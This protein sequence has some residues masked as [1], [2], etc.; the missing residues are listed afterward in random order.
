MNLEIMFVFSLFYFIFFNCF[1]MTL[2]DE[3]IVFFSNLCENTEPFLLV[4]QG[5]LLL[6]I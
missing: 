5:F 4:L 2:L 6:R 1:K 3:L